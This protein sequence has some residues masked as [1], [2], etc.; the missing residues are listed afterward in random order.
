MPNPIFTYILNVWFENTFFR[1]TELRDQTVL[2][3]T[4]QFS[5]K[6]IKLN[7][8]KFCYLLTIEALLPSK[9]NRL[10]LTAIAAG[11]WTLSKQMIF[12]PEWLT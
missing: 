9:L 10:F 8:S 4:I 12:V 5:H 1:Y 2:F 6:S 11:E 3:L 7:G